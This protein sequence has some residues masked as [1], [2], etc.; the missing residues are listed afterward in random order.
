MPCGASGSE[1]L[2][3]RDRRSALIAGWC[4]SR[5]G[6][7]PPGPV[8]FASLAIPGAEKAPPGA[9]LALAA[10]VEAFRHGL[11]P[12][13]LAELDRDSDALGPWAAL[14]V[15]VAPDEAKRFAI[16]VEETLPYGRLL[17]LDVYGDG[18]APLDRAALGLPQRACLACD[19]PARE[20][21]RAGRHGAAVLAA[22]VDTLLA[23]L[24]P[25]ASF[26]ATLAA[27]L[28][29][30]ARE[31]L[32]LT[33]KPG[34]V[35]RRDGGSHPD[36][37]YEAML[38]SIERLPL[39]FDELLAAGGATPAPAPRPDPREARAGGGRSLAACV[40][41]GTRAEERMRR[42]AGS[43]AHRGLIF[44]GGLLVLAASDAAR[45]GERPEES[46]LRRRVAALA[47]DVLDLTA[48]SRADTPGA[49][50]RRAH[51]V[52]GIVGEALGGLP[53]VFDA[54]LPAF[55]AT[56]ARSGDRRRAALRAMAALM[57]R[58]E[59]T[60][61]LHRAGAAGL[62]RVRDDGAHL[63]AL[64]DAGGDPDATLSRWN[65]EYRRER[66]TMG[67]V[68]DCLAVTLALADA[69]PA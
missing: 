7:S 64:L 36:L 26:P 44:L 53:A 5:T 32:D 15:D 41:A 66:L 23:P 19:A 45:D 43:N 18:G 4:A 1:L 3:A 49:R 50:A 63:A 11:G 31:E 35:D 54:A 39:Y 12:G 33:P 27:A 65:D 13:R 38:R 20:C 9:G 37:S 17:D 47:A 29:R 67:G 2:D 24:A 59:D 30:G 60:T 56:L 48:P 46:V 58:L 61:A 57:G 40:A 25:E 28:E 55:R 6:A 52:G 22:R 34:L 42:A 62:A 10:G 68:A 16:L 69:V 51:G 8:V 21:I 14:E